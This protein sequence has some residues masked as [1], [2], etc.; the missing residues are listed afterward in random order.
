MNRSLRRTAAA[1]A[2]ATALAL[3]ATTATAHT[4]VTSSS[5]AHGSKPVRPPATMTI[6]FGEPLLRA[7]TTTMTRNGSGQL[8]KSAKVSRANSRTV[9]LAL[10]RPGPRKWAGVYRL[11]WRVT[12]ADGHA[13]RGVIVYRVVPK[14]SRSAR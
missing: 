13:L 12:G 9:V 14:T 10:K 5:P 1:L 2:G 8:V 7:G 11:T 4:E 3:A 6:T